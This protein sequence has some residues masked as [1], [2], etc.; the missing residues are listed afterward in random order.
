MLSKSSK[1]TVEGK[2]TILNAVMPQRHVSFANPP[3]TKVTDSWRTNQERL[4]KWQQDQAAT[5]VVAPELPK[6]D[7]DDELTLLSGPLDWEQIV[8]Q[9]TTTEGSEANVGEHPVE[10]KDR[11]ATTWARPKA[12]T[13]G[14][15]TEFQWNP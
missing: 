12:Q 14:I 11:G 10:P 2:R 3:Q 8:D 13:Q 1:C 15:R 4:K 6:E 7:W 5:T 9:A